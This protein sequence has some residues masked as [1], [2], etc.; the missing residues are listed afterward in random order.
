MLP[1]GWTWAHPN[2][3]WVFN[4]VMEC[5]WMQV[6]GAHSQVN[7][8]CC[9]MIILSVHLHC[10]IQD[11]FS[12]FSF[13]DTSLVY[14]YYNKYSK[15]SIVQHVWGNGFCWIHESAGRMRKTCRIATQSQNET[16][17]CSSWVA[18][19]LGNIAGWWLMDERFQVHIL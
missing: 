7:I 5:G 2:C 9:Y 10:I 15:L 8:P 17:R 3:F 4:S 11:L 16:L 19:F 12:Y 6:S 1:R 14:F 13:K 18:V